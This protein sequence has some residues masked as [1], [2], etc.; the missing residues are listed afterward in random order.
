M[1]Y[2]WHGGG[3]LVWW[4]PLSFITKVWSPRGDGGGGDVNTA[5]PYGVVV[6]VGVVVGVVVVVVKY[7]RPNI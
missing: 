7:Y 2:H 6:V 5:Q 3:R 4:L 1:V